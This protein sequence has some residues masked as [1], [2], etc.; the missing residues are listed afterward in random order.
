[1]SG[2]GQ[3]HLS[4]TAEQYEEAFFDALHELRVDF[5]KEEIRK[6]FKQ[7]A[8]PYSLYARHR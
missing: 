2:S 5:L 7:V 6:R 1:M 3:D 4:D 8:S